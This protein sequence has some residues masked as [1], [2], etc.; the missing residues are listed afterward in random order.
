MYKEKLRCIIKKQINEK[1]YFID[2]YDFNATIELIDRQMFIDYED[3]Q[4]DIFID[5]YLSVIKELKENYK[6]YILDF[7]KDIVFIDKRLN[8]NNEKSL[9]KYLINDGLYYYDEEEE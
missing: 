6:Y 5:D 1:G 3:N 8:F 2:F 9:V 7:Y 4:F